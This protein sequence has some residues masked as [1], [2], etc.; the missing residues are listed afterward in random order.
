MWER[1]NKSLNQKDQFFGLICFFIQT[2]AQSEEP[3]KNND[4]CYS[5]SRIA[6]LLA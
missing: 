5:I 2:L 3:Q 1:E 6:H 4:G